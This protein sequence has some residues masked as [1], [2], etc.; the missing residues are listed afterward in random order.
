MVMTGGRQLSPLTSDGA[1]IEAV[2]RYHEG[3]VVADHVPTTPDRTEVT[4]LV[5]EQP[6]LFG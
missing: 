1:E 6:D 2:A 3:E 4:E 5:P